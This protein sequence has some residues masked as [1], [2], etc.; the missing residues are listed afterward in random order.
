MN[1]LTNFY[2]VGIENNKKISPVLQSKPTKKKV[3]LESSSPAANMCMS[4]LKSAAEKKLSQSKEPDEKAE[5]SNAPVVE[6]FSNKDSEAKSMQSESSQETDA[7]EK[8]MSLLEVEIISKKDK[9]PSQEARKKK[10]EKSVEISLTLDQMMQK[11][12]DR[13]FICEPWL[14]YAY[15][16]NGIF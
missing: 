9:S 16:N 3:V 4:M 13:Y 8:Q 7:Q 15:S 6:I 14:F 12:L 10:R 5:Q 11:K 2:I 1:K